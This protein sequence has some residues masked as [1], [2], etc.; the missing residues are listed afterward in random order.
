MART[1]IVVESPTKAR[2]IKGI[3]GREYEVVAS[4]GH[5]KD[6]P[7]REL[8][9]DIRGGFVP[10]YRVI[11]GKARV[12]ERIRRSARSSA[13]VLLAT[14]PDREGEAIAWHI[15][16]ELGDGKAVERVLIHEITPQGVKEALANPIPLRESLYR[17]QQARR[18]LDRLVGYQI[19][20]LLW[21]A[22]KGGLSAGRVQSVALRLVWERERE[23]EGFRPEEYWTIEA[24]LEAP[25]GETFGATLKKYSGKAVKIPDE[26][27]ARAILDDLKG[28]P[29]VVKAVR[30]KER[31]RRPPP[32]FITSTLQQEASRCLGMSVKEVMAIA[33]RLYEGVDLGPLGRRGLITYMRTD[34]VRVSPQ[35]AEAAR[36]WIKEH[37]GPQFLPKRPHRFKSGEMAQEAH[38]AIRPTAVD[39]QP[40]RLRPYLKAKEYRL[41]R[42]IWERFVASQMAPA[43]V[44]STRVEIVAGPYMFEATGSVV[45]FQGFMVILGADAGEGRLPRLK[46]GD[47]LDVLELVPKQHFTEPPPRYTE[48]SL[49]KEL[50]RRGIGRPST[51]AAIISTLLDRG[52]VTLKERKFFLTELGRQVCELLIKHFPEVMDVSFTARME[53]DLDRIEEGKASPQ[54]VL[55]AFYRVF[56]EELRKAAGEMLGEGGLCEECGSPL[57]LRRG[58]FGRFLACSAWPHCTFTRSLGRRE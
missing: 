32:P 52:Y 41:Y 17:A 23:I 1:L 57:V 22:L 39:L 47:P 34:S 12:L 4:L 33:Q 24:L 8:G 28:T 5:V 46:E 21:R 58:K 44:L 26:A 13:K 30:E 48:G 14:D 10:D 55:E 18:V 7:E 49:V 50:E 3:L 25:G 45:K 2:T 40:D 31:A 27:K 20:P 56:S 35:A 43:Q 29:F 19:S 16:E 54:E 15:A 36:R 51:Y 37:L 9:V 38:E 11:P 53:E 6:L 42:L